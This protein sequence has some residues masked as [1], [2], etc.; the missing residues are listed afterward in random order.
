MSETAQPNQVTINYDGQE[1]SVPAGLNLVEA[2]KLLG[3]EI[4]HYCY[5]EKLSVAGNCRMCLVETGMPMR[6]RATGEPILDENGQPKIGWAPKPAIGCATQVS[7]GLHVRTQTPQVKD[8]REGVTEFLLANHPLDCPI[9]DKAGECRLQEYSSEYGRN[10]SR[11]VEHKTAK[12]KHVDIGERIILDDERCILCGRC[13]RFCNEIIKEPCLGFTERGSHATL[14]CH[15]GKRFDHNYSLNTVDICPVGALTSKDFRF[16]MRVWFLKAADGI[17]VESSAGVNVK[18]WSREGRIY[19]IT[20]RR[21]DAVN[22][23]WMPDSGRML[24]KE[25]EADNRLKQPQ[26]GGHPMD[27]HETLSRVAALLKQGNAAFVAS[28]HATLEEMFLLK[29]LAKTVNGE[30]HMVP[31]TGE[32][33]GLLIA[34]D[35]TPNLRGALLT[36]LTAEIPT[37]GM[38]SLAKDIDSGK[39]K[40]LLC[41]REDLKA[42]GLPAALLE[43]VNLIYLGSHVPAFAEHSNVLIPVPTV[44]EK[45][46]TFVNCQWRAQKFT[47]AIPPAPGVQN[48]LTVLASIIDFVTSQKGVA[49]SIASVWNEMAREIPALAGMSYETLPPEGRVVE[50]GAFAKLPFV[51]TAHL[52]FTPNA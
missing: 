11:F 30:V 37:P 19:R 10:Y 42:A 7:P 34:E 44:Y 27:A 33:D 18:V 49:P 22:D 24:Y 20:P 13:I 6:D 48:D 45:A 1:V 52:H 25:G 21:N 35:K 51:E 41:V 31:H 12:P 3:K 14:S 29:R 5:H 47:Q 26:V 40:T 16:Q 8:C 4:P 15:P 43:K 28:S 17:S 39:I 46:G 32:G 23:T 38:E 36:G 50:A 9:C 2:A